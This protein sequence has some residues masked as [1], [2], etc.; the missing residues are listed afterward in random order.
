[1]TL[2]D[3]Q[4]RDIIDELCT[5]ANI[6]REWR[7]LKLRERSAGPASLSSLAPIV[8]RY[9]A[10]VDPPQTCQVEHDHWEGKMICG[11]TLPCRTHGGR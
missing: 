11:N 9:L 2:T 5:Q 10:I 3:Q 1:M 7:V 8:E 4:V 6:R